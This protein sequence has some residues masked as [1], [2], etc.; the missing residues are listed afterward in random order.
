MKTIATPRFVHVQQPFGKYNGMTIAYT[1]TNENVFFSYSLCCKG[2]QYE[3]SIGRNI[4]TQTYLDNIEGVLDTYR[5]ID[6]EK[7]VG[8]ITVGS[9][10]SLLYMSDTVTSAFADHVLDNIGFMDVKHAFIS[11]MLTAYVSMS[12]EA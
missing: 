8:C 6:T 1:R 11:Q 12:L 10:Q 3:K 9:L 7:R 2:D 5:N 4:S